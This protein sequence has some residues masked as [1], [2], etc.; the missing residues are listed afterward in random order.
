MNPRQFET[1][2][3]DEPGSYARRWKVWS[4]HPF[5]HGTHVSRVTY[6]TESAAARA[7][8]RMNMKHQQELPT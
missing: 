5:A 4:S 2:C 7:A 3:V 8:Y 1:I 6:A